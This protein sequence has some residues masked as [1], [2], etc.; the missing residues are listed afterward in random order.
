MRLMAG[1]FSGNKIDI[2]SGQ[3]LLFS[4][5]YNLLPNLISNYNH[6]MDRAL[7]YKNSLSKGKTDIHVH[8]TTRPKV[9]LV[10]NIQ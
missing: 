8:W 2:N 5:E 10:C 3:A 9:C 6:Y 4:F 7:M 1:P